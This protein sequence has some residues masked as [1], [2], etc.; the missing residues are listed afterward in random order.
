MSRINFTGASP[1]DGDF[2]GHHVF[3]ATSADNF[4]VFEDMRSAINPDTG[5]AYFD[6]GNRSDNIIHLVASDGSNYQIQITV[7]VY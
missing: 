4:R 7:T 1:L 3:V 5:R 2:P 6:I